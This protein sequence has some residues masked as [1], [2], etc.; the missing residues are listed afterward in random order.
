MA[1][2][3]LTT[4]L[5]YIA[6]LADEP[7]LTATLLKQEFDKSGNAIK[8]YINDTLTDE[9]DTALAAKQ[10]TILYT[11]LFDWELNGGVWS[12]GTDKTIINFGDY[13]AFLFYRANADAFLVLKDPINNGVK[14]CGTILSGSPISSVVTYHIEATT[15]GDDLTNVLFYCLAHISGSA[16]GDITTFDVGYVYGIF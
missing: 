4:D 14:G 10:P 5:N 1:L 11:K 16:H 12:S 6:A 2:T 15:S 9:L 13:K 8:T 3:A 7:L